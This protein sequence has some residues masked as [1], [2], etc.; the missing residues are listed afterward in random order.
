ML[1]ALRN[2][3]S[4][5]HIRA[6]TVIEE[7]RALA[8]RA[9]VSAVL[10]RLLDVTGYRA[11]LASVPNGARMVRNVEK[12]LADAHRSRLTSLP[13]FLAYVRTLRDVGLREGEAPA[14]AQTSGAVQLM[15]VHKAK[16]LE[17]PLTVLADAAYE[18]RTRS[19]KVQVSA[20]G[21]LLDLKDGD[22]HPAAWQIAARLEDEREEAEDRRLLYVAATRAKEKLLVSGHVKAKKDGSLSIPGWLGKLGLEQVKVFGEMSTPQRTLFNELGLAVTLYLALP[23][24]PDVP[25]PETVVR[26][27]ASQQSDLLEAL[28]ALVPVSDDKARES[29]PPQRVWRIVPDTQQPHA[30][31]WVV[32]KLVHEALHRWCFPGDGFDA[33]L[34]PF[35]IES[36]LTDPA[37]I[38]AAIQETRRLLDHFRAHPLFAELDAAERHHEVPYFTGAGRGIIDLLYR[39]GNDWVIIDFKT[40]RTNSEEHARAIIDQNNYDRQLA[41]YVQALQAQL[42]VTPRARLVFLNLKNHPAIFD[43]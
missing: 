43:L 20:G 34:Q 7:L 8:G 27:A 17:F 39:A 18:P 32:G 6:L 38:Q 12:L 33:F 35:A 15:T 10:K 3:T 16:G 13:S 36:G 28:T 40:D 31:A 1:G 11:I 21:L 41:R 22:F 4:P 25:Q 9:P 19:A 42:G 37:E 14:D 24:A 26:P 23:T 2:S 30:P 5:A 29:D